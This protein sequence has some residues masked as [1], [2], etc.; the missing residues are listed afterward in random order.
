M[1]ISE[2][3]MGPRWTGLHCQC[4]A[5]FERLSCRHIW[6]S[7]AA[8]IVFP[9]VIWAM[10]AISKVPAGAMAAIEVHL[11]TDVLVM[12]RTNIGNVCREWERR[13]HTQGNQPSKVTAIMWGVAQIHGDNNDANF[14]G[15]SAMWALKKNHKNPIKGSPGKGLMTKWLEFKLTVCKL[16][17]L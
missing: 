8:L 3:V 7:V 14:E 13:F 12:L 10:F 15:K 17:A 1:P 9:H 2:I 11:L 6:L 5:V 4:L 16:G